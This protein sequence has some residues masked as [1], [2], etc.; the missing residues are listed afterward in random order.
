MFKIFILKINFFLKFFFLKKI[1][2][3]L[4][5]KKFFVFK[6]KFFIK[7]LLLCIDCHDNNNY[8]LYPELFKIPVIKNQNLEYFTDSIDYYRFFDR[9]SSYMNFIVKYLSNID[10]WRIAQFICF[11]DEKYKR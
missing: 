7:K 9:K 5:K 2:F 11:K 6:K 10:I 8:N 1:F 3:F 4:Y